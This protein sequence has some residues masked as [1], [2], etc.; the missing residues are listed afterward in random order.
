MCLRESLAIIT[1]KNNKI[2]LILVVGNFFYLYGFVTKVLIYNDIRYII[3]NNI[4]DIRKFVV[5]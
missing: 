5:E 4:L 1:N 3:M 2:T